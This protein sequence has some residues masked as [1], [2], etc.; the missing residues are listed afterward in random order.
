MV[1]HGF[2]SYM[3]H[4]Y[5]WDELKPLSCEGRR[6]DRRERGTLDDSLGGYA[7]T[8][9]DSLSILAVIRD[10]K[11]FRAAVL[12]IIRDVHFDRDVTVSVFESTIRILG[13]LVSS[14]LLIL[15]FPSLFGEGYGGELL[16]LA[17]DLG[18]RLLPAYNT[19]TGIPVHRINLKY[20]VLSSEKREACTAG[21]GTLLIE[22]G[23]LSQLTGNSSYGNAARRAVHELWNRRSAIGLVGST[24]N[25]D[26][27]KWLQ[28][29]SGI[30]A[31]ID[32]FYEYLLKSYIL[33]GD[34]RFLEMFRD[35]YKGVQEHTKWGDWNIEVSMRSGKL[36]PFSHRV[37]A[38][39]AFW[40]SLQVLAGDIAAAKESHK[41]FHGLWSQFR[42]LPEIFD[43]KTKRV[44]HFA[45]DSPL[46]PELAES[47]FHLFS[48]T[49]DPHYLEVGR[50]HLYALQNI[51]RVDCGFASIAD[52]RN[53]RLDD[54]MDSFVLSETLKYLFLL[55][56]QS[57]EPADQ[58]S[59]LC[60]R[61]STPTWPENERPLS[62]A[63]SYIQ[64][65]G[66]EPL[67][68]LPLRC[69]FSTEGHIFVLSSARETSVAELRKFNESQTCKTNG[70]YNNRRNKS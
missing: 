11:R 57:L 17:V 50:E 1:L 66:K 35:A 5:P 20:G 64:E 7:L 23:T 45:K 63:G 30:G 12:L 31:G 65:D 60:P 56:D 32:S 27:G 26:N 61:A 41:A 53:H 13:G 47:T 29:H 16:G 68:L 49:G 43:V 42:A 22:M 39:Q 38:L 2:E 54:R 36:S 51:S 44:V 9:I 48:A 34:V 33:F 59:L 6:W 25:I 69:L 21:A 37:S 70:R 67:C 19:P 10:L 55:F 58:M 24:I 62:P 3:T 8:L 4:A 40:P 14:H 28:T 46:R 18:N 15:E 52:V